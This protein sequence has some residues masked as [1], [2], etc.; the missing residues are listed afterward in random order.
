MWLDLLEGMGYIVVAF[1]AIYFSGWLI[2]DK[3]ATRGYNLSK[4]LSTQHPNVK[5][6]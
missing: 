4:A 2:Y 1:L 5:S 6:E 3:I